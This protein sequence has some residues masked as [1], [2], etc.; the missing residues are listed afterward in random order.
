MTVYKYA[1]PTAP[2]RT[3]NRIVASSTFACALLLI[4][5]Y[6]IVI[7]SSSYVL[8]LHFNTAPSTTT[9]AYASAA[10]IAE[11]D[12]A[13]KLAIDAEVEEKLAFFELGGA[14][15]ASADYMAGFGANAGGIVA[16]LA[17]LRKS[18]DPIVRLLLL[19]SGKNDG[20]ATVSNA[21]IEAQAENGAKMP[22]QRSSNIDVVNF[23]RYL[24]SHSLPSPAIG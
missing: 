6:I 18:N 3:K 2:L 7:C 21:K 9:P 22:R 23:V 20:G 10:A 24:Y 12:A 16:A 17:S 1:M 4:A 19:G 14:S 8:Y 5:L 13:L 11:V 15:D